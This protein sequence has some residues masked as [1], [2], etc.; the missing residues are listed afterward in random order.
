MQAGGVDHREHECCADAESGFA[1]SPPTTLNLARNPSPILSTA[2]R[3]LIS[4]AFINSCDTNSSTSSSNVLGRPA[5]TNGISPNVIRSSS[6]LSRRPRSRN[7]SAS[8]VARGRSFFSARPVICSMAASSPF[9]AAAKVASFISNNHPALFPKID[10][11]VHDNA[12]EAR[13]SVVPPR[14]L[15]IL[16]QSDGDS[17]DRHFRFLSIRNQSPAQ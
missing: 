1:S 16:S 14:R 5:N 3:L 11:S 7:R 12:G 8:S 17:T 4:P 6:G 2:C 9:K 15:W 10:R 13:H